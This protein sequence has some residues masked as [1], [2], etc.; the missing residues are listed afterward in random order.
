VE[1]IYTRRLTGLLADLNM[2]G[3]VDA[4]D[5]AAFGSGYSAKDLD[6]ADMNGDGKMD[7]ADADIFATEYEKTAGK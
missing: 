5:V 1:Y 6:A 3:T 7:A 2:S 4:A